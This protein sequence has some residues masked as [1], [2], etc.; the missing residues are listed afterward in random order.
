MG[1]FVNRKSLNPTKEHVSEMITVSTNVRITFVDNTVVNR[2][3]LGEVD[4]KLLPM[5]DFTIPVRQIMEEY[6]ANVLTT[7]DGPIRG[8]VDEWGFPAAAIAKVEYVVVKGGTLSKDVLIPVQGF[9]L[10][11]L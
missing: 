3:A 7:V 6:E 1:Y 2:T 8:E 4:K 9:N 11:H 5:Y 10:N